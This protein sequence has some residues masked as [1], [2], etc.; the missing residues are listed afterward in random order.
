MTFTCCVPGCK[1]TGSKILHSFPKN[2]LRCQRWIHSTKC[3]NL[4][5]ETAYKTHHKVCKDHFRPEDYT[6]T[7]RKYLKN[8]VVPSL[9]LP[10]FDVAKKYLVAKTVNSTEQI[11]KKEN[12]VIL[13]ILGFKSEFYS[14]QCL[15]NSVKYCQKSIRRK[16][17]RKLRNCWRTIE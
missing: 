14:R 1:A 6:S 3:F 2:R 7:M 13:F 5:C 10:E 15:F 17:L 12:A 9:H 4:S 16:T 11:T 8:D